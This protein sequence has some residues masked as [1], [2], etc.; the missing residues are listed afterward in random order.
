MAN[1]ILVAAC[2]F[3]FRDSVGYIFIGKGT[4]DATEIVG[5]TAELSGLVG[6][7]YFFL[8][9][10]YVAMGCLQGMQRTHIIALSF[11]VGAWCIS[12]PLAYV[13][14]FM[15]TLPIPLVGLW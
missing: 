14:G 15:V 10:F 3:I 7:G 1:A 2:M 9:W 8:S 13:L 12:V 11:I 6:I 5:L 4:I